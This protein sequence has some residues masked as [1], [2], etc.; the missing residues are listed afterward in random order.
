MPSRPFL[1]VIAVLSIV[2]VSTAQSVGSFFTAIYLNGA[3]VGS[4]QSSC[5]N[6]GQGQYCCGTGQSCAWDDGNLLTLY[7]AK[8]RWSADSLNVAGK[9]ACCASGSSCQGSPYGGQSA[10]AGQ[11]Y[12]PSSTYQPQ[13][14]T[15]T[16]YQAQSTTGCGCETTVTSQYNNVVPV[17]P[18]TKAT[19]LTSYTPA[20]TTVY[21]QYPSTATYAAP[22]TTTV[23]PVAAAV[24]TSN[25]ACTAGYS[26]SITFF[27]GIITISATSHQ[28]SRPSSRQ[29]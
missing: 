4:S 25:G 24:V 23:G 22:T 19:L 5:A 7:P 18:V 1:C 3:P 12:T 6:M 10:A 9:V 26:V 8:R 17:V 14:Q 27:S 29:M 15:T 2:Q 28:I 13:P 11:Y 20:T 16:V 21:S